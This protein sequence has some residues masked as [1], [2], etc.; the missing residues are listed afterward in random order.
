MFEKFPKKASFE[1]GPSLSPGVPAEE[2]WTKVMAGVREN[3]VD[4]NDSKARS[5]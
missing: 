3:G 2:S 4:T 5:P 1:R